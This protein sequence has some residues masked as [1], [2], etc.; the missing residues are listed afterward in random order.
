MVELI[1]MFP[2][3]DTATKWFED[4]IWHGERCC[5]HCGSVKTREASNHKT[6]PVWSKYSNA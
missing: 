3:E 5:G 4:A 1:R 2:N 6:M